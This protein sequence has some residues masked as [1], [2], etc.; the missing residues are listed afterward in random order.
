ML[1]YKKTNTGYIIDFNAPW[2]IPRLVPESCFKEI[3]S[4]L[5]EGKIR[6]RL[7]SELYMQQQRDYE[8]SYFSK[9]KY[10]DFEPFNFCRFERK[11]WDD[12]ELYPK[13]PTSWKNLQPI[14][15]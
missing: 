6:E 14:L 12:L 10:P 13:K 15:D 1:S 11:L 3:V 7:D 2:A 9:K 5:K 4:S 8:E